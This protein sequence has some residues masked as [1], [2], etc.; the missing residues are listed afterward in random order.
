[1]LLSVSE[2]MKE[3]G[4][5]FIGLCVFPSV[6]L[7]VSLLTGDLEVCE[8]LI[9]RKKAPLLWDGKPELKFH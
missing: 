2:A 3:K 7:S 8:S 9:A 6:R 1:M 5:E 4:R